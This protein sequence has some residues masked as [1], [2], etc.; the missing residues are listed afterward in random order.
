MFVCSR[1]TGVEMEKI[2]INLRKQPQLCLDEKVE[3]ESEGAGE[4][5]FQAEA[6]PGWMAAGWH[7][8]GCPLVYNWWLAPLLRWLFAGLRDTLGVTLYLEGSAFVVSSEMRS[9]PWG[10]AESRGPVGCAGG[11]DS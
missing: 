5:E 1:V 4:T 11:E 6:C 8:Y 3:L 2:D 9:S 7:Q 10:H